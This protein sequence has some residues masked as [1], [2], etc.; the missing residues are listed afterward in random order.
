LEQQL[1]KD[2]EQKL[3]K[4]VYVI[5]FPHVHADQGLD[6]ALERMGANHVDVLPVV[7]RANVHKLEGIVT[8]KDVLDAYGLDSST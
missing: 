3:E 6:Q 1:D 2:P 8:L 4:I 7:N 5:K